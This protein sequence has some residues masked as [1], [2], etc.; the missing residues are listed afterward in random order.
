M[1][2][3]D[4]YILGNLLGAISDK[5]QIQRALAAYD[6]TRRARTQRLVADSREQGMLFDLELGFDDA[7]QLAS[8]ISQRMDWLWNYDITKELEEAYGLLKMDSATRA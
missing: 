2:V 8:N 6:A 1:A 7:D 3:E 5:S 4:A